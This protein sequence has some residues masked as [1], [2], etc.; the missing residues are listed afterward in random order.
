MNTISRLKN[1]LEGMITNTDTGID[2]TQRGIANSAAARRGLPPPS[3]PLIPMFTSRPHT[4]LPARLPARSLVHAGKSRLMYCGQ[5][6]IQIR[7]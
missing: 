6:I 1:K 3:A 7:Q 5:D 4:H 2:N